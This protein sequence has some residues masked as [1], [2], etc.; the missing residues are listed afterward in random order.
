MRRLLASLILT[1]ALIAAFPVAAGAVDLALQNEPAVEVEVEEEAEEE[2]PWTSRFLV[3]L[4]VVV[5]VA[6]IGASGAVYLGRVKR[7][8]TVAE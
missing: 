5:A 2:Q 1:V 6:S 8:Y 4:F 3:P 7:R